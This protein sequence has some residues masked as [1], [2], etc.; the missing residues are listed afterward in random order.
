MYTNERVRVLYVE[1]NCDAFEMLKVLFGLSRIDLECAVSVSE[2]LTRA[3]SERF[4]LYLLDTEL[5]DGSGISLC[6]TLRAV[7][8]QIPVLFYSGNAHPEQIR[9]G[10]A[11]G[12]S[13]YITKP[14]SDKL[15][16]TIVR[17]LTDHRESRPAFAD[18]RVLSAAA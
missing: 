10:M 14:N 1:D 11:A 6:R 13:G 17:V 9:S 7:D 3:A 2:A 4:D 5:P 12:A 8:P 15:A 18:Y 16:A